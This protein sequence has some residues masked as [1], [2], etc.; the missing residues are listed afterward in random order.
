MFAKICLLAGWM[1][2]GGG[3]NG[4]SGGVRPL[5]IIV[6]NPM[7]D[8]KQYM[9]YQHMDYQKYMKGIQRWAMRA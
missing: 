2:G 5:N 8:Y 1:S 4:G 6:H 7:R 9:D 3:G